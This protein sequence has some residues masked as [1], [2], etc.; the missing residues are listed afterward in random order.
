MAASSDALSATGGVASRSSGQGPI[1]TLARRAFRDGR[2][3]TIAFAYLFGV[4]SYV[5]PL[6]YRHGYPTLSSR[7]AF[8]R[9]RSRLR[10][11][12]LGKTQW[13]R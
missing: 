3:R 5:Q 7:L 4:Y 1:S 8:S 10:S 9:S 13:V 2:T 6:A 11:G 12:S